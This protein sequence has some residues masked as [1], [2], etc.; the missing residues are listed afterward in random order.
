MLTERALDLSWLGLVGR[1]FGRW[2]VLEFL[3]IVWYFTF[4]PSFSMEDYRTLREGYV[5]QGNRRVKSKLSRPRDR[6]STRVVLSSET[7]ETSLPGN[8]VGRL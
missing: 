3:S 7:K 6:L 5:D 2:L 8:M 1:N 4:S